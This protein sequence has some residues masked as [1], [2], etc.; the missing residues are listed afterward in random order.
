M[1]G[2]A[3]LLVVFNEM[4]VAALSVVPSYNICCAAQYLFW[5]SFLGSFDSGPA[6]LA[7]WEHL[8]L[9][10]LPKRRTENRDGLFSTGAVVGETHSTGR[11]FS[12]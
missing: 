7:C 1:S 5:I 11:I 2:S 8:L 4:D 6:L 12:T 9:S 3:I 10:C